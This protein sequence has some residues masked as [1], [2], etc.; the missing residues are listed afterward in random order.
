[1]V[2]FYGR[3][4]QGPEKGFDLPN[5]NNHHM[6]KLPPKSSPREL[7]LMNDFKRIF[8]HPYF[9]TIVEQ[10]PIL[11][12]NLSQRFKNLLQV[13]LIP[14]SICHIW[15]MGVHQCPPLRVVVRGREPT[16]G[17]VVLDPHHGRGQQR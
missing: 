5:A 3:E 9:G 15:R 13:S 17:W 16:G 1:M 14:A 11:G 4:N 6:A 10:V 8:I 2:P 12:L 7:I